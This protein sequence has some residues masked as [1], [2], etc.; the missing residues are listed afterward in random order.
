MDPH[1]SASVST[2]PGLAGR[3]K[4]VWHWPRLATCNRADSWRVLQVSDCLDRLEKSLDNGI[5][6]RD[7]TLGS[8][9][10][11]L[12]QTGIET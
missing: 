5:L 1:L 7:Y 9:H 12:E 8:A 6:I 3:E 11:G 2:L 4:V 10:C